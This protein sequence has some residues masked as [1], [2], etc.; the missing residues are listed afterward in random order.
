[1]ATVFRARLTERQRKSNKRKIDGVT[2]EQPY[3]GGR[4]A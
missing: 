3:E 2:A 4:R 1:M